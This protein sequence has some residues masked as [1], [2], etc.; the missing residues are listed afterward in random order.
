MPTGDQNRRLPAHAGGL[1]VWERLAIALVLAAMAALIVVI[2]ISSEP[3]P[4]HPGPPAASP[5]SSAAA[6]ALAGGGTSGGSG[7]S[8]EGGGML[9]APAV[10]ENQRLAA[11]LAPVLRRGQGRLAI[12]IATAQT[13]AVYGGGRS[14]RA[15]SLVRADI[16]AALLV[17]HQRIGTAMSWAQRRL[18]VRM[19][20]DDDQGAAGAL[21]DAVGQA[22]GLAAANRLLRLGHTT[23]GATWRLTTT[24]V[25]DQLRLLAD[26][27]TTASPLS[28]ASRSYELALMRHVAAGQRWGVRAAAPSARPA[29]IA[30]GWLPGGGT[31]W[32]VNSIGVIFSATRPVLVAVLCDGAPTESAG[33]GQVGAAARAAVSVIATGHTTAAGSA[34]LRPAPGNWTPGWRAG[35]WEM[36]RM[37]GRP[38]VSLGPPGGAARAA[39]TAAAQRKRSGSRAPDPVDQPPPRHRPGFSAAQE[40][41]PPARGRVRVRNRPCVLPGG[42]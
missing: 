10:A 40:P 5:R 39:H 38:A 13:A 12:G 11:A 24:T 7:A 19:I 22:D 32:V 42:D 3:S 35:E 20:E 1:P 34:G 36:R 25:D 41:G 37:P 8:T 14:F 23:P 4:P 33:I 28:A 31:T 6:P 26:L 30:N 9:P 15:A 29:A 17:Q 21:W 27:T 18:A 2:M 16:L